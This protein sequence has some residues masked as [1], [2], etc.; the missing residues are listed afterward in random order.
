MLGSRGV[1]GFGEWDGGLVV[2][3]LKFVANPEFCIL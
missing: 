2:T 3:Y 1:L